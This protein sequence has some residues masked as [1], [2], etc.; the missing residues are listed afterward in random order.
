MSDE[1]APLTG[2]TQFLKATFQGFPKSGKSHTAALL[3]IGVRKYFHLTKP[4]AFLDTEGSVGYLRQMILTATDQEPVGKASR[5]VEDAIK[6]IRWAEQGN[7]SVVVIDSVSHPWKNMCDGYLDDVNAIRRRKGKSA[8]ARLPFSAWGPLKAKW[9]E[10]MDIFLTSK[11]H[12]ILCGRVAFEYDQSTNEDGD[13]ELRKTG[14]KITAEKDTGYE[15]AL[16]VEMER[17]SVRD[18]NLAAN[19][20]R[21]RATVLG[22]RF[23]VLDGRQFDDP[24]FESFLPHVELLSPEKHVAPDVVSHPSLVRPDGTAEYEAEQRERE[25]LRE[26]IGAEFERHGLAGSLSKDAMNRKVRLLEEC[27]GTTSK[28]E[29]E[30][31]DAAALRDGLGKLTIRLAEI[32]GGQK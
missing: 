12:V 30:G 32:E 20:L 18:H 17:V 27:F 29:I 2:G 26:K 14:V 8:L 11:V 4:I 10:F 16:L 24:T 7:A 15:C 22:D 13:Q 6:L 19:C 9:A 5:S 3:A 25:I 23:N 28:T 31:R 1:F 21:R